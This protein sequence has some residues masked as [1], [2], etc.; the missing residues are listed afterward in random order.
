[1]KLDP[2][3]FREK[4]A[5]ALL[6]KALNAEDGST[7]QDAFLLGA[8]RLEQGKF[9]PRWIASPVVSLAWQ[10]A[11]GSLGMLLQRSEIEAIFNTCIEGE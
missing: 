4:L 11:Y 5:E 9:C 1:M 8:S 3:K 2:S 6:R 7:Q 10:D